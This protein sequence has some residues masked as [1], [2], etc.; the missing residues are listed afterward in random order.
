VKDSFLRKQYVGWK[1]S[2][3]RQEL[4][5]LHMISENDAYSNMKLSKKEKKFLEK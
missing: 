4:A 5:K 2:N 3:E 1:K